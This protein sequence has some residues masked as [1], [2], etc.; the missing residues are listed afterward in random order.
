M[1][2]TF[3]PREEKGEPPTIQERFFEIY[4]EQDHTLDCYS[5]YELACKQFTGD[6]KL[7]PPYV[8]YNSFT[9]M[10]TRRIKNGNIR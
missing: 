7:Q 8:N 3:T 1:T 2:Y 6:Y 10:M 9:S 4:Y 5:R